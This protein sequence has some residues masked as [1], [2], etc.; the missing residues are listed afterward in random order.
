V[1]V[2]HQ[3]HHGLRL[4][5]SERPGDQRLDRLL[6]LELGTELKWRVAIRE[7]ERE[8]RCEEGNHL[9]DRE[10]GGR[11]ARFEARELRLGIVSGLYAQAL[12]HQLDQRMERTS[13][14][15]GRATALEPAV[16]RLGQSLAERL[17]KP[18][19]P[20]ARVAREEHRLALAL[21]DLLPAFEQQPHLL[22]ASHERSE[23][24]RVH[25]EAAAHACRLEHGVCADRIGDALQHRGSEI[26]RCE[27]PRDQPQRRSADQHR[28]RLGRA[29]EPRR[30]VRGVAEGKGLALR[31]AAHLAHDDRAGVDADPR[32][33]PDAVLRLERLVQ[34]AESRQD[35]ASRPDGP[36]GVVLVR[37]R[38][39]E[40]DEQAVAQ[41]LG[42]VALVTLDDR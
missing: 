21:P 14:G 19:L 9:R 39:P 32:G 35:L 1:E 34:R 42:D 10:T 23:L 17:E 7:R 15:V 36:L 27:D 38:V 25:V 37:L 18:R 30:D 3:Q 33:Q 28:V 29:F 31:S 41:V 16:G 24:A 11:D 5:E 2:L 8:E 13:L 6:A 26:L 20:E 22:V 40:V 4:G 12:L